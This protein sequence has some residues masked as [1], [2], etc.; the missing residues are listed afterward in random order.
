MM[1]SEE[2]IRDALLIGK[3]SRDGYL[4]YG[5]CARGDYSSSSDIDILRITTRR[6]RSKRIGGRVS[7]HVY[8]I[9]DLRAMA[10]SG[11]LFI[12][13]LVRE[14]KPIHDPCAYLGDL[15]GAFQKPES[16]TADA[17]RAVGPAS[18]LLDISAS[19]FESAPKAFMHASLYLCR[20]LLY[21]QHAD[22]GP[23]SFSLVS[24]AATDETAS[25]LCSIKDQSVSYS[26]FRRVRQVVQSKVESS[27][28]RRD[29]SSIGELAQRSQGDPLFDGLLR[30]IIEG[31]DGD[32][33]ELPCNIAPNKVIEVER[34]EP[35][36]QLD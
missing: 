25:M 36:S 35:V 17:R 23:F 29:A 28:V 1:I 7:L 16:Y 18:A 2:S 11:S 13:H 14:S 5:S 10:K 24:L 32:V 15:S 6:E 4:L 27:F 22:R 33:Y 26:D 12:L 20:T 30:R 9:K 31:P 3:H 21:A 19:L 34:G 8:D